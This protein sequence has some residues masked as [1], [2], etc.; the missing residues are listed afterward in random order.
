MKVIPIKNA[1]A[2]VEL[3]RLRE[4]LLSGEADRF[5]AFTDAADPETAV[6]FGG[7]WDMVEL[8]GALGALQ[9]AELVEALQS[10]FATD[11]EDDEEDYSE[12]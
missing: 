7:D 3:E 1:E 5:Y 9:T 11:D 6:I 4:M 10:L 8:V 2:I 12:E